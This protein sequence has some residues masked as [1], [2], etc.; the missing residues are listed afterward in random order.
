[1]TT[2]LQRMILT[3]RTAAQLKPT[4]LL[5][6]IYRRLRRSTAVSAAAPA[7]IEVAPKFHLLATIPSRSSYS[8]GGKF[9]FIG[10]QRSLNLREMDWRCSDQPKL[11]RYNLHYFDYFLSPGF[12]AE[13]TGYLVKDWIAANPGG[14]EIAW[15]PYPTSL[16]LVNWIKAYAIP[17][18]KNVLPL[19]DMQQ[20]L[21][22]Q[23]RWLAANVEFH[24]QANHLF[25][26]AKALAFIGRFFEGKEAAGWLSRAAEILSAELSEQFLPDGGHYE[27]S[28]MYHAICTEDLLDLIN[29]IKSNPGSDLDQLLPEIQTTTHRALDYLS[30]VTHPDGEIA[31][32]NDSA[33]GVAPK[34]H[35]IFDY[36]RRLIDYR[37][38][39]GHEEG[40][41][42]QLRETGYFGYRYANDMLLWDCGPMGPQYQPGHGHCDVLSFELTFG[43]RRI[44]V[45]SGVCDYE[46]SE[47]R[48]YARS[49]E[50]HNTIR[51]DG[52]DQSEIWHVF[53]VA[54]P[55]SVKLLDVSYGQYS[56]TMSGQHH[57]YERLP[58]K[59]THARRLHAMP[60]EGR[61][62]IM[63]SLMG[64]GTH[65]I[66]LFVHLHPDLYAVPEYGRFSIRVR[67][68]RKA[69][70]E[71][72]F[73]NIDTG[74][75]ARIVNGLYMPEFGKSLSNDV[76]LISL[77]RALPTKLFWTI[78]GL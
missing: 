19:A 3:T 26:N 2:A 31:L 62:D 20:S 6:Q 22:V 25:K 73:D 49:T 46:D 10:I 43:G 36:A 60:A 67:D 13:K 16:R 38:R 32:L 76:L 21:Y 4:Q 69:V 65:L 72:T 40:R 23:G 57:G 39:N 12:P 63:D 75:T 53:R 64:G 77:R 18:L 14:T 78:K 33:H 42:I 45:D 56:I 66:E 52:L 61:I 1:M 47:T 11:W 55:A 5:W 74:G 51:V 27:R 34:P 9:D 48:R 68:T 58:G 24:I 29:L 30:D 7:S 70:A 17:A 71:I 35:E 41:V 59:V 8:G 28:P 15:E 37:P 50:G 54:R 44:I